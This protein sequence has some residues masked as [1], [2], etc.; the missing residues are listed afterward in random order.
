VRSHLGFR[1]PK[2]G[3]RSFLADR[4]GWSRHYL[5]YGLRWVLPPPPRL[6]IRIMTTSMRF[7]F[8]AFALFGP[9]SVRADIGET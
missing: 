7:V 2:A 4:R 8:V 3:A 6:S 9:V 5:G 1:G